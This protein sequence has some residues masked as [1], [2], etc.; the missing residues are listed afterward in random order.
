MLKLILDQ[1]SINYSKYSKHYIHNYN[2]NNRQIVVVYNS[3]NNMN[4]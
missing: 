1:L 3:N 2:S 4:N